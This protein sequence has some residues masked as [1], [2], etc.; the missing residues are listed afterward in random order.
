MCLCFGWIDGIRKGFDDRSFLQRYT[1]RGKKSIWSRINVDNVARLIG[2]GRMTEHGLAEAEAA[3]AEGRW[4]R[5]YASVREMTLPDDLLSAIEA[6]PR[7]KETLATLNS[8]NRYALAFRL[9]NMKTE[10]GRRK[11]IE[12]FVAMLKPGET[13]YPQKRKT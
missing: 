1:P 9:H 11:K 12:S 8:Q 6:E 10:A 4:D 3:K 13:I 2:E 7:A 5:A